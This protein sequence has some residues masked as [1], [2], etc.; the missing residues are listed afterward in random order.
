MTALAAA[1]SAS[2]PFAA[3]NERCGFVAPTF[4]C[5]FQGVDDLLRCFR[6]LAIQGTAHDDALDGLCHV[7]PGRAQG[8][9]ERH[10]TMFDKPQNHIWRQ[11]T[12]E[13]VPHQQYAQRREQ[14]LGM[15]PDAFAII[16]RTLDWYTVNADWLRQVTSGAYQQYYDRMYQNR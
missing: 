13:V 4:G 5:G 10:D 11:V 16:R 8:R 9:V 6:R 15:L 14:I 1:L 7:E 12:R 3:P 2:G